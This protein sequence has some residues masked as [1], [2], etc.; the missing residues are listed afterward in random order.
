[1]NHIFYHGTS[2]LFIDSIKEEG[3]GGINPNIEYNNLD[4]LEYLYSYSEKHLLN[5]IRYDSYFREITLAMIKQTDY[6]IRHET[7]EDII[8]N[9]RHKSIY[10]SLSER[11][12]LEYSLT[13]KIGSEILQKCYDLYQMLISN[14][15]VFKIP[16]DINFYEIDKLNIDNIN[17]ILIKVNNLNK[18]NIIQENGF[19]GELMIDY[20][21]KNYNLFSKEQLYKD[22]Q[23]MNFSLKKYIKPKHLDFYKIQYSHG[24]RRNDLGFWMEISICSF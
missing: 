5:D 21:N 2:S 22:F 15:I 18:D 14:N 20:L 7:K 17:P 16:K 1:M 3:L 13:N 6:I 4:L 11:K 19:D 24:S 10:V 9:F 12:A 23:F 8:L